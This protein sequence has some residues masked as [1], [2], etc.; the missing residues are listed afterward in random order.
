LCQRRRDSFRD[1]RVGSGGSSCC[2]RAGIDSGCRLR[3]DL[4]LLLLLS[5]TAT[6]FE[7]GRV[8]L[9]R[10]PNVPTSS[11]EKIVASMMVTEGWIRRPFL[12][13]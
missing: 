6:T 11:R 4:H 2:R 13:D 8:T 5:W 9:S 12:P 7:V 1:N 3:E 10:C